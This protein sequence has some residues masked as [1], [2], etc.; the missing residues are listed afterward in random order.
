MIRNQSDIRGAMD[1]LQHIRSVLDGPAALRPLAPYFLCT[2]VVWLAYAILTA[3]ITLPDVLGY[4]WPNIAS[5]DFDAFGALTMVV[6]DYGKWVIW[7][8]LLVQCALWQREKNRSMTGTARRML[9]NWQVLLVLYLAFVMAL[10]VAQGL[11]VTTEGQM[12]HESQ[13]Y[14]WQAA[15]VLQYALLILFPALPLI[16]TGNYLEDKVLALFGWFSLIWA[17]ALVAVPLV[18]LYQG[19]GELALGMLLVSIL[20][21]QGMGFLAPVG[22]LLAAGRLGK[23]GA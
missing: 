1:D 2:G 7:A 9:S 21:S 6:Y 11:T 5:F 19:G 12:F 14:L 8:F 3:A 16:L 10:E 23:K 20:L 15:G 22:L 18:S 13:F 17:V 4:L